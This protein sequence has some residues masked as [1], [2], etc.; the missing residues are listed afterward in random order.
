MYMP[1]EACKLEL[2]PEETKIVCCKDSSRHGQYPNPKFDFLGYTFRPRS[3]INRDGELF[4]SFAPAVS[5]KAA[6][7][8]RQRIRRWWLHRRND[9]AF[10]DLAR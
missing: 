7:G 3:A 4:V 6:K 9:P 8:M 10:V 1:F 5:D 2:H